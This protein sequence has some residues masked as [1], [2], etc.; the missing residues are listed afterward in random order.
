MKNLRLTISVF[1][2]AL[3]FQV[4]ALAHEMQHGFILSNNDTLGSHLVA[5]GHHSRQVE[6]VGELTIQNSNEQDFYKQR[7]RNNVLKESYFIFQAQQL[8][9]P[10]LTAGQVLTGHIV[11]SKVGSYEPKN[12]IVRS[13]SFQIQK[14][15]LN[16]ENPFFKS[17]TKYASSARGYPDGWTATVIGLDDHGKQKT[18]GAHDCSSPEFAAQEAMRSCMSDARNCRPVESYRLSCNPITQKCIC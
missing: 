13:A 1:A 10:Q 6:V 15:L 5:N 12:V 3:G 18:F 16:I 8:D 4:N 17:E 9:L 7:K 2:I 14:V 11:E